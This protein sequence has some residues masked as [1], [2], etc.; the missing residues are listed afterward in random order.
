MIATGITTLVIAAVIIVAAGYWQTLHAIGADRDRLVASARATPGVVTEAMLASLPAPAQRY[1]RFAGVL[2][3][4]IPRIVRLT[5]RGRIRSRGDAPWMALEATETYSTNPPAFVWQAFLPSKVIPV[6]LGR[7]EFLDGHG[8]I[9]IKMLGL[10][11]VADEHGDELKAAGLMRYLN[12]AM[13]FPAALL[14]PNMTVAAVDDASFRVTLSDRGETADGLFIVDAD[15][16]LVNFRAR[17][18]NTGTRSTETWETPVGTYREFDGFGL[19]SNGSAVWKLASG[20]LSY[21]ELEIASVT[22]DY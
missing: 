19:P 8:S 13:W 10:L 12:E 3:K 6:A 20:D 14:G 9:L 21:I 4:P 7:D 16:H 22:Y 15:G 17:R 5:Q 1:F 18:Y 2:G 11:P